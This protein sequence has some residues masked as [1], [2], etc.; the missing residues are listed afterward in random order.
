MAG[1]LG[2]EICK[3]VFIPPKTN[4]KF[5]SIVSGYKS[6]I[7]VNPKKIP[8]L[9]IYYKNTLFRNVKK[10]KEGGFGEIYLVHDDENSVIVKVPLED[11]EEEPMV[12]EKVLRGYTHDI[13]PYRVVY[14]QFKNPF[15]VMQE[16]NGT[17]YDLLNSEKITNVFRQRVIKFYTKA[18]YTFYK[19]GLVF[20]DMKLDNLLYQCTDKGLSLFFG[21]IGSFSRLNS[22]DPT[23]NLFPPRKSRR[24][25]KG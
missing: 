9:D 20:N 3:K 7:F 6:K 17:L 18:I 12:I 21:D 8:I 19:D 10:I 5:I 15:V 23:R 25:C 13:I 14:D 1:N 4:F 11:F 22:D 16:A 2:K 24:K